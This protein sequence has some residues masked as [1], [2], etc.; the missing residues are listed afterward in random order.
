MEDYS[1]ENKEIILNELKHEREENR[2]QY[3]NC[4]TRCNI[5]LVIFSV[6]FIKYLDLIFNNAI[7]IETTIIFS[8]IPCLFYYNF[9][10]IITGEKTANLVITD[11]D[12]EKVYTEKDTDFFY[13]ICPK[14]IFDL[15]ENRQ[16][17]ENKYKHLQEMTLLLI[18]FSIGLILF[19]IY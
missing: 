11:K 12:I 3:S 14:I 5:L 1:V 15:K 18:I 7:C 13:S 8:I 10:L 6:L 9:Y 16:N 19:S 17:I 4:L 2:A